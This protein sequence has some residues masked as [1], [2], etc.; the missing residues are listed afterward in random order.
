M[1]QV[2]LLND[3]EQPTW[4]K[5]L[6]KNRYIYVYN[7]LLCCTPEANIALLINYTPIENKNIENF[8]KKKRRKKLSYTHTHAVLP[9]MRQ[10][11]YIFELAR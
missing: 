9:E 3:M 5:N 1:A 4:E 11:I 10:V 8:L 2:T 7:E 6:E